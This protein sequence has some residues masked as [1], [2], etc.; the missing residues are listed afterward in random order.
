M[1]VFTYE[2]QGNKKYLVYEKKSEDSVDKLTMEMISNNKIS[3]CVSFHY[4]QI[5]NTIYMKYDITGLVSL[6]EYLKKTV[7]RRELLSIMEKITDTVI[8][9][10]D[11]MLEFSSYVL[12]EEYIYVNPVTMQIF[13]VVL[14][15]VRKVIPIDVF[16][17]ELILNVKYD[18]TEDCSYVAA[19]I[20][21]FSGAAFS[22]YS[23]KDQIVQFKEEKNNRIV[24]K[25]RE[26]KIIQKPPQI[27]DIHESKPIIDSSN[28]KQE[29]ESERQHNLDILFSGEEDQ[30]TKKKK[31]FFFRK[32]KADK[33]EKKG[34]WVRKSENKKESKEKT[35]SIESVLGEMAIPG[36]DMKDQKNVKY[37]QNIEKNVAI[38]AQNVK[39]NRTEVEKYD[40]GETVYI[41]ENDDETVLIGQEHNTHRPEFILRRC[42][43]KEEFPISDAVTRIGRS[44]EI[45]EI[46]ITGNKGV[47]RVHALLYVRDGQV[48]IEDNNSKNKTYIDGKQLKP[49]DSP[50]RLISGTKIGLGDEELEFYVRG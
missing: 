22:V 7:N 38:P 18:Q 21:L 48:F 45:A 36:M 12:D 40:F 43:T 26:E 31:G 44:S 25:P 20:N 19:L 34:F 39:I 32:E 15:I 17:K 49:G 9:A 47:G 11:Y 4:I 13:M 50:R 46:C 27:P 1:A 24:I 29:R 8:A 41:G 2:E 6:R 42:S 16:L 10:E 14:P 37:E 30:S 3:G 33:E 23:F 35:F 28:E 5:N